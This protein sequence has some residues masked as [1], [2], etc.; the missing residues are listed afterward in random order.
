M[1]SQRQ[2][3]AAKKNVKKAQAA[4]KGMTKRERTL[5]QPQGRGRKKPGTTGRGKFYRIVVRPKSDFTSFR[6]QDVGEKGGLERLA[7]RRS[8]GSWATVSW[9]VS[10]EDAHVKQG[11]LIITEPKARSVLESLSGHI[12]HVK[13]DIFR[14]HPRKNVPEA[15]KPTLAMRRAQKANIKKA[16]TKRK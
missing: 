6:V 9:L 3:A 11:H 7:G 12:Y 10:K 4:W 8:S 16:Q 1:I 5:A 13:G 15:A 2:S 14:A